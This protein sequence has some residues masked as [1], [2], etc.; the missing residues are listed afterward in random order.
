MR[1]V[2]RV[3][4]CGGGVAAIEALLAL[5]EMLVLPPHINV[6]APNP[7]FVYQPMA[8]AEPFGQAQTRVFEIKRL[9]SELDAHVH[10]ETIAA[11]DAEEHC[12]ELANGVRLSYD[13][14]IV[15]V[16]ARRVEWLAGAL[17]FGGAE[18]TGAFAALLERLEHGHVSRLAFTAPPGMSW[19]LPLYELA[20]LTSARLAE[21][22]TAGVQLTIVTPEQD[23]LAIF[24]ASAGEMLRGQLLDRGIRIVTGAVADRFES[25]RLVLS[26]TAALETDAVVAL[27]RLAG[28]RIA[29]LPVDADG[30][31][32]IDEHCRVAGLENVY[33]AGD[34]TTFPIKQGGIATQQADVAAECIAAQLRG[35]GQLPVFTPTLRGMLLTGVAPM[36]LRAAGD[37]A[38]TGNGRVA[39]NSLWWPPTKIAGRYLG[40]YLAHLGT[41]G[42]VSPLED[43]PPPSHSLDA[44]LDAHAEARELALTFALA[45]ARIGDYQSALSWLEVIERL[46]GV[47]PADCVRRRDEWTGLVGNSARP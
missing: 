16:G 34:G 11:V 17:S 8:V 36:F 15:A 41:L 43:R 6:I 13:A 25:G 22:G 18:D 32:E 39:A 29:G 30:F 42:G 45:D 19:T 26:S 35:S 27:P 23:P 38:V 31:I 12:V 24:G 47:M 28:P 33:A 2:P 5:R 9:A 1:A 10:A 20:L 14:A 37:A 46:E 4:I 3:V 44:S 7:S 21:R 40:P